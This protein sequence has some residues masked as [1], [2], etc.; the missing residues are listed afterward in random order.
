MTMERISRIITIS[1]AILLLTQGIAT[2][3]ENLQEKSN[4]ELPPPLQS[5]SAQPIQQIDKAPST[6]DQ[7]SKPIPVGTKQLH[8]RY[9]QRIHIGPQHNQMFDEWMRAFDPYN[10]NYNGRNEVYK[11]DTKK[12]VLKEV[13]ETPRETRISIFLPIGL[14]PYSEESSEFPLLYPLDDGKQHDDTYYA[15]FRGRTAIDRCIAAREFIPLRRNARIR[16]VSL[17]EGFEFKP[18]LVTSN[19]KSSLPDYFLLTLLGQA[20][21]GGLKMERQEA[22]KLLDLIRD[23][24]LLG[25]LVFDLVNEESPT[26]VDFQAHPVAIFLWGLDKLK[27][28]W[29]FVSALGHVKPGL[30][31]QNSIV[32]EDLFTPKEL[33][34]SVNPKGSSQKAVA[35]NALQDCPPNLPEDA[36]RTLCSEQNGLIKSGLYQTKEGRVKSLPQATI[37]QPP[38]TDKPKVLVPAPKSGQSA[39]GDKASITIE[40]TPKR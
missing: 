30:T 12:A 26:P 31:P 37:S 25:Q 21:W 27:S 36:D 32:T 6:Q 13:Y 7:A 15:I 3:G 35:E 33:S 24:M 39:L 38:S 23:R 20:P 19:A 34:T 2:S 16:L 1:V 17:C 18:G 9:M 40:T 5:E 8:Y 22:G 10:Q 14:G 28:K 4:G 11:E 29:N